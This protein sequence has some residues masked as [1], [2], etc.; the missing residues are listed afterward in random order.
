MITS[1]FRH[2]AGVGA[3]FEERLWRGGC[4]T[5]QDAAARGDIP[6]RRY[7]AGTF[8]SGVADSHARLAAGD[9]AWF[10]QRLGAAD[11]WRLFAAFRH[12]AAYVDI[13][14][15]GLGWPESHIT[16]IALWDGSEL[17]TYVYGE[18]LDDFADDIGAYKLL[19]TFN[20]RGF[21]APFIEQT[22]RQKLDMAHLDL[23]WVLKPL[24]YS[25][26]LKR[27][28]QAF[29]LDRGALTGVDGYTAVLLWR[30]W[31][32]SGD[33]RALETLLAYN[34]EDVLTLEPLA[35]HAYNA[36]LA[37]LPALPEHPLPQC[38]RAGN[39]F[40]ASPEVLRKVGVRGA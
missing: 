12:Q 26:G 19:V 27:V 32:N 37:G 10:G 39:P 7:E 8:S 17:R 3:A 2:L 1:T 9:A 36:H 22:F 11:Q 25:G 30:L 18:N 6:C 40:D 35:V 5:W 16:T 23:R 34:A 28:E 29:G 21:D 31:Q 13:E 15:T 38:G 33:A 14:T 20:G 4:L 24:G